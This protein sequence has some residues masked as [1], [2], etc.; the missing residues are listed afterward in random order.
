M[1]S[2]ERYPDNFLRFCLWLLLVACLLP[3]SG[4]AQTISWLRQFGSTGVTVVGV[5]GGAMTSQSSS[6]SDDIFLRRYDLNGTEL[7]TSQFGTS[8]SDG[9]LGV[10]AGSSC[11]Y[12]GGWVAKALP[13]QTA[14]GNIAQRIFFIVPP[15]L[16][17]G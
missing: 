2:S 10:T 7:W 3:F 5:A 13:G 11:I 15:P 8:G 17:L 9:A 16:L 14:T 6:V 12:V 1:N 4:N